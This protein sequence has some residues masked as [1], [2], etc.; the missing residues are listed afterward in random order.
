MVVQTFDSRVINGVRIYRAVIWDGTTR[1][2]RRLH[3]SSREQLQTQVS[4]IL[5]GD[6]RGTAP[7]RYNPKTMKRA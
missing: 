4:Q 3:S 7:N 6:F 5:S 1:T 2:R